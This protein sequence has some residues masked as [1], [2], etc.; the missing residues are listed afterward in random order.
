MDEETKKSRRED[1]SL[2]I[3]GLGLLLILSLSMI[4]DSPVAA[5]AIFGVFV[6][7]AIFRVF[8]TLR[9]WHRRLKAS[10]RKNARLRYQAKMGQT[11]GPASAIPSPSVTYH[12]DPKKDSNADAHQ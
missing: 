10:L 7:G 9:H 1:L 3:F 8:F 2:G 4:D 11:D 5:I 6:L 12:R